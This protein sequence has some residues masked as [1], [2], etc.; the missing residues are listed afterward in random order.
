VSFII[1]VSIA[2]AL[3][4]LFRYISYVTSFRER[5][6]DSATL[7]FPYSGDSS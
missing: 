5:V 3:I 1:F 2:I 6:K 7:F 4:S